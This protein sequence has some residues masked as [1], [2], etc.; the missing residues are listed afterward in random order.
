M[1]DTP[2]ATSC[3]AL[4]S[5]CPSLPHLLAPPLLPSFPLLTLFPAASRCYLCH[6]ISSFI[7]P[8][9]TVKQ[10]APA[11][12]TYRGNIPSTTL[13]P[14][15]VLQSWGWKLAHLLH[16]HLVLQLQGGWHQSFAVSSSGSRG[17]TGVSLPFVQ[18]V[19]LSW[20]G[21]EHHQGAPYQ[22]YDFLPWGI[23]DQ[24]T[25]TR[26]PR[27]ILSLWRAD[28][29]DSIVSPFIHNCPGYLIFFVGTLI[30]PCTIPVVKWSRS[31]WALASFARQDGQSTRL[32]CVWLRAC[33]GM[34]LDCSSPDCWA[35]KW[36]MMHTTSCIRIQHMRTSTHTDWGL[37]PDRTH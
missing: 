32:W 21:A 9:L 31:C 1:T 30:L 17:I 13:T 34:S 19:F 22:P 18:E 36:A 7:T 35:M 27:H 24:N 14:C 4:L 25:R 16:H 11:L 33:T 8:S 3:L 12:W 37:P 29:L 20:Q 6:F 5:S 26:T 23:R 28:P 15:S 2:D 10:C